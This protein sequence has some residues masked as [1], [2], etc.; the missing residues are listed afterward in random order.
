MLLTGKVVA[1][2]SEDATA[3]KKPHIKIRFIEAD[4]FHRDIE[5]PNTNCYRL[6]DVVTFK[7]AALQRQP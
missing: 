5:V 7:L 6:N 3:D 1:L 2:I 4:T